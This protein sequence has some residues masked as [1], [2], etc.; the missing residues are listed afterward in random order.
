[1]P[2]RGAPR[3]RANRGGRRLGRRR[4]PHARGRGRAED[5]GLVRGTARRDPRQARR[6]RAR[7]IP[8]EELVERIWERDPTVW[9][10]RDEAQW[11]GWLDEP[12]RM[13]QR[14]VELDRLAEAAAD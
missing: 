9:T 11:L 1:G 2:R 14:L 5:H 6:A 3:V 4:H 10:G 13:R 7:L 12:L 8:P